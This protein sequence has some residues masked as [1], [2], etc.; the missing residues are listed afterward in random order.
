MI[1]FVSGHLNVTE[2]EFAEHYL[3]RLQVAVAEACKFVVGDA[4]GTDQM[5]QVALA[6]L[7]A[8]VTVFHMLGTP[9][10]NMGGFPTRGG[11]L[12]DTDRDAAM[13]AASDG[14]IAWV[15]SGREK[16][17]TAKNLKRRLNGV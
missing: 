9:R 2:D 4:R 1:Y 5:A 13:T 14:D 12:T 3:P 16:S 7:G 6:N 17:G 10:H 8:E 15:R 11:F